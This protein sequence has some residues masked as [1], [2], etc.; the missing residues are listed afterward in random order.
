MRTEN[1]IAIQI[2]SFADTIGGD[3]AISLVVDKRSKSAAVHAIVKRFAWNG[4]G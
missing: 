3:T 1:K 2:V 4:Q